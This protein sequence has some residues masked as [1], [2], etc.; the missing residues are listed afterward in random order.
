M[1]NYS[2]ENCLKKAYQVNWKIEEVIGGRDFDTAKRWLPES[3]SA[4]SRLEGFTAKERRLLTHV[5]MA[6]YAHLFAYV[7]EFIAPKVSRLAQDYEIDERVAYDALT[8]FAAEEVKHMTLFKLLRDKVNQTV[9][10]ETDL[11]G[12]QAETAHFVLSKST[13]AVL[14]LTACIEWFTQRHFLDAFR[15]DEELDPLTKDVFQAHWKEESQ[16]AQMDHL[17][18]VRA[19]ANISDK[20]RDRCVDELIELVA[21]V[22]GLLVDQVERDIA[23]FT[24]YLGRELSLNE[25]EDLRGALITSKRWTFIESGVT[26]PRFVELM[27]EVTT[28][29]QRGRIGAALDSL[30]VDA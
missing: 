20:E 22:D 2:Y 5:E 9:G 1:A 18:T 19:F 26:H 29:A 10:F 24:T 11:I 16:H 7:E 14:L 27:E 6:A 4:V 28:D 21:A 15:D 12:N 30:L 25:V 13:G 23:N 17:E 8:N 3:L